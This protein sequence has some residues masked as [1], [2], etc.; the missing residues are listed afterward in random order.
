LA[1]VASVSIFE[2]LKIRRTTA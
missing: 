2:R 1:K